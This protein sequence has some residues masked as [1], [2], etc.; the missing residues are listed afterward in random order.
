MNSNRRAPHGSSSDLPVLSADQFMSVTMKA[1]IDLSKDA[2]KT[3]RATH[4]IA[5]DVIKVKTLV[6]CYIEGA[7]T[8]NDM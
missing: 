7:T 2:M 8:P 6:I 4:K 3:H 5:R 1:A